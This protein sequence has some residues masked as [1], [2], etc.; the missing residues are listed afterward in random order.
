MPRPN[1]KIEK[2]KDFKG[3][4]KKVFKGKLQ[5]IWILGKTYG[6]IPKR[7]ISDDII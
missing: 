7:N 6:S 3:S 4:I 1:R 2:S 5:C